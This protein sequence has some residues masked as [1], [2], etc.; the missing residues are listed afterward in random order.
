MRYLIVFSLFIFHFS[1]FIFNCSVLRAQEPAQAVDATSIVTNS[2]WDNWYGQLGGDMTL[3]FPVGHD[4][5]DVFPNGKGLGLSVA[6]GKWFSPEFGGKFKLNWNNGIIRQMH[7]VWYNP[8][9]VPGGSHN[10]GGFILFSG[11]IE[12]NVH[13]LFCA[14]RPDRTWNLIVSPRAGG[15]INVKEFKGAP[16][17]GVGLHNT[18]RL[19]DKWQLF[20]DVNY[21]FVPS[22]NGIASGTDHGGN[23]FAEIIVGAEMALSR[24]RTFHQ[25]SDQ[26]ALYE[27]GAVLNSFWDNWFVQAGIDMTLQ[28]PYGTNF[29]NVF[30]NGHSFGINLGLGKWFTPEIGVRGGFNWQNSIIIN[31]HAYWLAP[32]DDPEGKLDKRGFFGLYGDLFFNLH[33]IIGGYDESRKWNAIFFP[34]MG[35]TTNFSSSYAECPMIG[36]GTEQTYVLNDRVK[37]F[38][39]IAF[40]AM[41]SGF[42]DTKFQSPSH[43]L[44]CNGYVDINI[45]VQLDLGKNCWRKAK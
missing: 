16:I 4:V 36:F 15:W 20:G 6:V 12:L 19:S 11:D 26:E 13:N 17:L 18:Y 35:L 10:H 22:L 25:L 27:K 33:N 43:G 44:S 39:D 14:Y 29:A 2:F 5:K 3:L 24:H 23:S 42:H 40:Q 28:T 31:H 37:L 7:N 32:I 8:Y 21:N 34:R 1:L 41:T 30:P 9:G 38:A 45:G